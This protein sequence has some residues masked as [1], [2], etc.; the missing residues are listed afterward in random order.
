MSRPRRLGVTA[1]LV[2]GE[3]FA[4]DV[5]LADG[6]IE[7]VGL[8]VGEGAKGV[9]V[10]GFVDLQVN[11]FAG[12]QF[13][14]ADSHEMSRAARALGRVGVVFASPTL[15]SSTV[16]RYSAALGELAALLDAEPDCGLTGAHLEGPFLSPRWAGAHD[17]RTFLEPSP[18]VLATLCEAGPVATVTVAP[19]L[20]G[21]SE[22]VVEATK[23][24]L[25]VAVGHTDASSGQCREAAARGASMLTHCWNAHRRFTS[26]DP[27]PAGWALTDGTVTVGLVA[28]GVH[29]APEV[30][31]ITFATAAGRVALTTDAIAPAGT[32]AARWV[33]PDS[34][35]GTVVHVS[36]G[37]ARLADGTLAGSV[38]TPSDMLRVLLGAGVAFED[39]VG[40]LH[41][42]QAV[43]LGMG[44]WSVRPGDPA[45]VVVLDDDCSVLGVWRAGADLFGPG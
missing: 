8:P 17:P 1:A 37:A 11:G 7:S 28:D 15:Y 38:A 3:M 6:S 42:P 31:A 34:A 45:H 41:R 20:R 16:D 9:A 23:R 30:L 13:I 35:D 12:V 24:G 2:D 43:A 19:E 33:P 26:R 22:V 10:A 14:E 21:V 4:G 25:A 29:V 39:A 44:E 18:G 27:G 40:A 36:G 5:S 32:G